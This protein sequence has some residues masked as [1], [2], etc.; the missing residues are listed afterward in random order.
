MN[1]K[2]LLEAWQALGRVKL[3]AEM[4]TD[5]ALALVTAY[6]ALGR[7]LTPDQPCTTAPPKD[8]THA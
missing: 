1:S 3:T 8:N 5:K 7:F 2:V 6:D 4:P